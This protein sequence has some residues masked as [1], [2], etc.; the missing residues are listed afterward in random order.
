MVS[1]RGQHRLVAGGK[2]GG[3]LGAVGL[4][5]PG[6]GEWGGGQAASTGYAVR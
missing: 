6:G 1:I 2:L 3:K 4:E 5:A